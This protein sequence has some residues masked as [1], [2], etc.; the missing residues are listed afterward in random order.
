MTPL[1]VQKP[2]QALDE[3]L[4]CNFHLGFSGMADRAHGARYIKGLWDMPVPTAIYLICDSDAVGKVSSVINREILCRQELLLIWLQPHIK[5]E[6]R[7]SR[8]IQSRR[9]CG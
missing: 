6:F 3:E 4:E 7:A 2:V 1:D 5:E 9:T 8:S